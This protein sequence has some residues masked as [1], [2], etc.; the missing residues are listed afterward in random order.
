MNWG[1]AAPAPAAAGAGGGGGG[2]RGGGN[3]QLVSKFKWLEPRH[4][5]N[6]SDRWQR[7][8]NI[9]LQYAFFN[10]VGMETWENIS[11]IWTQV[12]PADSETVRRIG[13]IERKFSGT[14]VSPDWGTH[15]HTLQ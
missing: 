1:Q 8:K 14:L 6:I 4:M 2:R 5:T 11:G 13:R 12:T 15:T 7:A 9:D 10:G 3:A